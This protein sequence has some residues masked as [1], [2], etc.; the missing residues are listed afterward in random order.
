MQQKKKSILITGCSSGI[1]HYCATQLHNRGY[2]VFATARKESDV[3]AL[4]E[5]GLNGL[6]LDL[7]DPSSVESAV[8]IVLNQTG[9]TLDALFNNGAY[10]LAGAVEDLTR[11]TLR[12]Q[13]E[14]NVFGWLQLTNLIIPVMRKQGHGRIIQNSSI[15]GVI[16][17]PYRG[18]YNASKFAIEGLTDTLR[19]ELHHTN[20]K[21][22]L[23]EPGP[24]ESKFRANAFKAFQ[25][26]IDMQNSVHKEQYQSMITRLQK[27]GPA[28]PFTLPASAVYKKLLHALESKRPKV[29]YPVTFPAHLFVFLKRILPDT[30]MDKLLL[31]A[32]GDG[33]R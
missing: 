22:S 20:I 32:S 16:T 33:G 23:I 26:H 8:D 1:G 4:I 25:E 7:L 15:L 12:I 5:Q 28:A 29:R 27:E 14:T 19:Q 2:Q 30:W 21:L 10:G 18:A 6:L 24:I 17:M 13:F 3:R 31:K 11:D 9:G